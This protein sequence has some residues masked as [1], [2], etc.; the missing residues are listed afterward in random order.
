MQTALRATVQALR[1]AIEFAA[2]VLAMALA[3]L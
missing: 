1:L 2:I 3:F